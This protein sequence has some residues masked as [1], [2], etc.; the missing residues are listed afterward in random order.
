MQSLSGLMEV[1]RRRF[2]AWRQQGAHMDRIVAKAREA[3]NAKYGVADA[4]EDRVFRD[5]PPPMR[6]LPR[7]GPAWFLRFAKPNVKGVLFV[8]IDDA[9]EQVTRI[10][11]TPR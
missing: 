11:S 2:E 6:D 5:P 4:K 1:V 8:E 3:V 7:P 9:T 10:W